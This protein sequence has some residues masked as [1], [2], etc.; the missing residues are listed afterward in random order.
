M[1]LKKE[2]YLKP[3]KVSAAAIAAHKDMIKETEIHLASVPEKLKKG[4]AYKELR[5]ERPIAILIRF[6]TS[7][8]ERAIKIMNKEQKTFTALVNEALKNLLDSRK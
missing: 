7:E 1:T 6:E 5:F 4:F 2:V 8:H 3:R